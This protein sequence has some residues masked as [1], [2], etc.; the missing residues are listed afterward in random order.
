MI[1]SDNQLYL[2]L[3]N[4]FNDSSDN[5]GVMKI[6]TEYMLFVFIFVFYSLAFANDP[7]PELNDSVRKTSPD[8]QAADQSSTPNK[9]KNMASKISSRAAQRGKTTVEYHYD[10]LG[11]INYMNKKV[12]LVPPPPPPDDVH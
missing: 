12:E 3:C 2:I 7:L 1:F 11:R 10:G 8:A 4:L 6:R 5:G 9:Q